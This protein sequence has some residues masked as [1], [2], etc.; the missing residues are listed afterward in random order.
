MAVKK[1]LGSIQQITDLRDVWGNEAKDFTPWLAENIELLNEATGLNL[2]VLETESPVGSFAVDILAQDA[3]TE[4]K[5]IIENQL[6]DTNH[7]HLG[8]LLT[9]AAGKEA[10]CLIWIVK[11][12][13]E[14]HRAAIEYLNNNTV[15]GI[16]LFLIEI[17]LWSIDGSAPAVKFNVVEQPNDWTKA[18]KQPSSGS[19]GEA[20]QIKYSYWSD[21]N[22]YVT[23]N[24]PDYLKSFRLHK[25]SSDHWYSVAIGSSKA[26]LSMLVNT[27]TNVIAIELYI[28]NSKEVFDN[29]FA[30]KE[31]IEAVVGAKL[32]WRRLDGKKSSR[33]LIERSATVA[34]VE[35]RPEQF[36]W[37]IDYLLRMKNAFVPYV[38]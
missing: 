21:F 23:A 6:E 8:K 24:R 35:A 13:R 36:D 29:C 31:E 9:Y 2:E 25:P 30:H 5:A 34:D 10:K 3:N 18:A 14:E 27:R 32:D 19:G 4:Q 26:N 17:Q 22:D 1:K 7:D 38:K 33:V 16:G 20:V 15:D 28:S 11:N 12:A 37:F